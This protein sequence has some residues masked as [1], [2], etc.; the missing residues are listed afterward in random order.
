M[1]DVN[2][3]KIE[4]S[5]AEYPDKGGS[6]NTVLT[7]RTSYYE[8]VKRLHSLL[9]EYGLQSPERNQIMLTMVR[10]IQATVLEMPPRVSPEYA[11]TAIGRI[12]EKYVSDRDPNQFSASVYYVT[13]MGHSSRLVYEIRQTSS[14]YTDVNDALID[15]EL[16]HDR[17]RERQRFIY[18]LEGLDPERRKLARSARA[19][20]L[21]LAGRVARD[22]RKFNAE[23]YEQQLEMVAEQ[24]IEQQY[25]PGTTMGEGVRSS[26]YGD[27]MDVLD[28]RD[29]VREAPTETEQIEDLDYDA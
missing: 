6:S 21:D 4:Y 10:E 28:E 23:Y 26:A 20:G 27:Q 12:L 19:L 8:N 7:G 18:Q 15:E 2:P 9:E 1:K 11:N 24:Q 25:A 3:I 5:R 22:P 29:A 16:N 14:E 17:E 13:L